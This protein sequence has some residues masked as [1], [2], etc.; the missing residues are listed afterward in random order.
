MYVGLDGL[1]ATYRVELAVYREGSQHGAQ[2]LENLFLPHTEW[3]RDVCAKIG[4]GGGENKGEDAVVLVG[5]QQ[6]IRSSKLKN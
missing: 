6:R 4:E 5:N 1:L 2:S 3:C